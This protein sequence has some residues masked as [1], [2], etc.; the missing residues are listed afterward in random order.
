MESLCGPLAREWR[1][2]VAW[3]TVVGIFIAGGAWGY[4]VHVAGPGQSATGRVV[5]LASRP[6]ADTPIVLVRVADGSIRQM[7]IAE[8]QL[9]RCHVGDR[10]AVVSVQNTY[11][12]D[13][14]GCDLG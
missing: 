4:Y 8:Y 14:H 10:I 2:T 13:V 7:D 11:R 3:W 5:R 9:A 6:D 1:N 12:V